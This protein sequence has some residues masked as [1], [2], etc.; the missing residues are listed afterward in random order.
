M[1]TTPA[2]R[3]RFLL[4]RCVLHVPDVSGLWTIKVNGKPRSFQKPDG[5]Y[6]V[7]LTELARV[8][9]EVRALAVLLEPEERVRFGTILA[10]ALEALG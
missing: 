5:L 1:E 7:N 8:A 9:D 2:A 4:F 6:A 10:V 3:L